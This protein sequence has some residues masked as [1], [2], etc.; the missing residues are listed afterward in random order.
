MI[1]WLDIP[2]A[3]VTVGWVTSKKIPTNIRQRFFFERRMGAWPNL[4]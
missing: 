3:L 4:E 2:S 1:S